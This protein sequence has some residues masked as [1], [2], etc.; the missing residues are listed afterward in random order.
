MVTVRNRI[1]LSGGSL[2]TVNSEAFELPPVEYR[3]YKV[4]NNDGNVGRGLTV[5]NAKDT[6]SSVSPDGGR[7]KHVPPGRTVS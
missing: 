7:P 5:Q 4:A 1:S 3:P 2:R 6:S